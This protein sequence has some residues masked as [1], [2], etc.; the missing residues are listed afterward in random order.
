MKSYFLVIWFLLSS[1]GLEA[2]TI[3][4]VKIDSFISSLEKNKKAFG[5]I[6]IAKNGK[7]LYSRAIGYSKID[8]GFKVQSDVSTKYRI[9]SITK[10]FTTVLIFDLIEED[11]LK[12]TTKL[13]SFY[14]QIK[15][16]GKITIADLLNHRSGIHNF[17]NDS[18][19]LLEAVY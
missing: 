2:Q 7:V 16:S 8:G 17:T 14:P 13:S 11:R 6:A 5:S 3:N 15:N 19:Y 12:L 9:G 10:V 18:M 1:L 4:T